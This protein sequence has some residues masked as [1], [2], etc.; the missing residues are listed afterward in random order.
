VLAAALTLW[1]MFAL[2]VA[3]PALDLPQGIARTAAAL[4]AAELV[5]LLSWSYGCD[6]ECTAAADVAGTAARTDIPVLALVFVA[7]LIGVDVR[8]RRWA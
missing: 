4:L 3:A 2:W 5:A 7:V 6:D 1:L 8:P